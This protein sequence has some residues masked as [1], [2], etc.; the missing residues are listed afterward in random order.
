MD[1]DEMEL[2]LP[3][4]KDEDRLLGLLNVKLLLRP[5]AESLR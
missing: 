2:T 5:E 1:P 4:V 3:V